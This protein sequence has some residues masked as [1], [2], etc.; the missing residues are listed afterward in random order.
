MECNAS[1]SVDSYQ[2]RF[3]SLRDRS[4]AMAFCCD[5]QG[6]VALDALGERARIDYFFARAMVG[7]EF[8]RPS[9]VRCGL[10]A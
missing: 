3:E 5:A 10:F 7:R 6:H 1:S 2:I 9:V 4:R 8:A